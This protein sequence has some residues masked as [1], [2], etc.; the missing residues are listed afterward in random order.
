M[1]TFEN[2]KPTVFDITRAKIN[3]FSYKR[4]PIKILLNNKFYY[5]PEDKKD[6]TPLTSFPQ[7]THTFKQNYNLTFNIKVKYTYHARKD[8]LFLFTAAVIICEYPFC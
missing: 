3:S 8:F 1:N 6:R 5:L 4:F 2:E 7:L